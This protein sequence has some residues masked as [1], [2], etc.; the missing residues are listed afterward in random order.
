[1]VDHYNI[2]RSLLF[3]KY[4]VIEHFNSNS[5]FIFG[6][7]IIISFLK[8]KIPVIIAGVSVTIKISCRI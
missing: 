6:G 1:M 3:D 5:I 2:L 8:V 7:S 4:K